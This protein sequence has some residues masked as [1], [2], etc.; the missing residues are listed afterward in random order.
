MPDQDKTPRIEIIPPPGRGPEGATPT[1]NLPA[2]RTQAPA[3]PRP[4]GIRSA[5]SW[6]P[7]APTAVG[8]WFY[9]SDPDAP[10]GHRLAILLSLVYLLAPTDFIPDFLLLPFGYADDAAVFMGLLKFLGSRHLDPYRNLARQW[11]RGR[12]FRE[13]SAECEARAREREEQGHI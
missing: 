2:R 4:K 1:P 3:A 8:L 5:L 6:L 12:T 10:P 11:L 7:G 9:M 13:I